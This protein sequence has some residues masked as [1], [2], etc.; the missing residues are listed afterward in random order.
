MKSLNLLWIFLKSHFKGQIF[1]FIWPYRVNIWPYRVKVQRLH[2]EVSS[3][4][5]GADLIK[6]KLGFIVFVFI[7]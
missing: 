3:S 6:T 4:V 1:T 2:H 7:S 5:G